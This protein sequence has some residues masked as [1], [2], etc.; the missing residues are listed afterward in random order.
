MS[1]ETN[2]TPN[3]SV[4][5]PLPTNKGRITA[6]GKRKNAV[7][8]L[9]YD[10]NKIKNFTINDKSWLQY[11]PQ[12]RHQL[13]ILS[14]FR[15]TEVPL[16]PMKFKVQGGGT[17]A[18]AEAIRHAISK[19]LKTLNPLDLNLIKKLKKL[20]YITRDDRRVERKKPGQRGARATFNSKKR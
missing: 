12:E 13:K 3:P 19:L 15:V 11:F 14:P 1:T 8:A 9:Q 5:N 20:G 2:T 17:T 16:F 18:Q 10:V 4:I 6:T 7:A